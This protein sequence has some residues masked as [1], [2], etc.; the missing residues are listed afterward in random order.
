MAPRRW[1]RNR[2]K[3]RRL[4][5]CSEFRRFPISVPAAWAPCAA[6]RHHRGRLLLPTSLGDAREVGRP[7][8]R[9]P[10][11]P[12]G[13][14][15]SGFHPPRRRGNLALRFATEKQRRRQLRSARLLA[16]DA[17][18]PVLS[19]DQA[20]SRPGGRVTSLASPREVTKRS[21][22]EKATPMM[23]VRAAHGLH[24]S[25]APKSGSVGTRCAQTADASDP[26]PVPATCRPRRGPPRQKQRQLQRQLQRQP[27][28][29]GANGNGNRRCAAPTAT[30]AVRPRTLKFPRSHPITSAS[31]PTP[32][33]A[34]ST[35][36]PLRPA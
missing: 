3:K 7:P 26:F 24:T 17:M 20:G 25:L 27:S 4:S 6:G 19:D 13:R 10:A 32:I 36:S 9:A 15:P 34:C 2:I 16:D 12:S 18:R 14:A 30:A 22:Q 35:T 33:P 5:E 8:G 1:D 31:S 29:R 28:L 11:C 23:A 21:N